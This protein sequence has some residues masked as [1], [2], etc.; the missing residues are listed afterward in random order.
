MIAITKVG[1]RGK[2]AR[3]GPD[4]PHRLYPVWSRVQSTKRVCEKAE[5]PREP[6][7]GIGAYQGRH[8]GMWLSQG[9]W[10][11]ESELPMRAHTWV[12]ASHESWYLSQSFP[13]EPILESKIPMWTESSQSY[14]GDLTPESS[15]TGDPTPESKLHRDLTPE[16]KQHRGPDS[17]VRARQGPGSR[18]RAAQG[19]WFKSQQA[20]G[21]DSRVSVYQEVRHWS[22]HMGNMTFK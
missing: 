10:L 9:S 1:R 14:P 21:T 13:W 11:K 16:S 17:R 22:R 15:Y 4:A 2:L 7:S 5:F 3:G 12:R 20:K 19:S 18:F 6:R 8:S